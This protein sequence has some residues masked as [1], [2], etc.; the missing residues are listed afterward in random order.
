MFKKM[1]L[2]SKV[3]MKVLAFLA[4]R[5]ES[6]FY[7]RELAKKTGIS[8]GAANGALNLLSKENL[9]SMEKRGALHF[10]SANI[11]NPV[12]RQFKA[13][14]NVMK[15]EDMVK[16]ISTVSEKVMLF[17]SC[18]TGTNRRSSDMDVYVLTREK[19]KADELLRK[20]QAASETK[21]QAIILET[22][23]LAEFKRRNSHL[24]DQ[25][26]SGIILWDAN[27]P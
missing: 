22:E 23:K 10:Y 24:Y 4:D 18:A 13:L 5:P 8:I 9:L 14:M 27:G 19:R 12:V 17:G 15:L 20:H 1:N 2:F 16:D 7:G 11:R 6:R 25:I 26:N 3:N 21:I